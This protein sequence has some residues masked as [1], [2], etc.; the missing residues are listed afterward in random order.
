MLLRPCQ[1]GKG[2]HLAAGSRGW[3]LRNPSSPN[4]LPRN[5]LVLSQSP[6]P[7]QWVSWRLRS[8]Y[9]LPIPNPYPGRLRRL[10]TCPSRWILQYH[11][12][13]WG[14]RGSTRSHATC[15]RGQARA[16]ERTLGQ[17]QL[18]V[19]NSGSLGLKAHHPLTH[20]GLESGTGLEQGPATWPPQSC[21]HP[22]VLCTPAAGRP[23]P[24]AWTLRRIDRTPV[25]GAGPE[26]RQRW[27]GQTFTH[28]V[29]GGSNC[30]PE[31]FKYSLLIFNFYLKERRKKNLPP[32]GSLLPIAA[33]AR[34]EPI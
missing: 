32:A 10:G 17:A 1:A 2:E 22:K 18:S 34:A 12:C 9:M 31:V 5:V 28:E 11:M 27:L 14:C 3:G 7:A 4:P 8:S 6:G 25:L 33:T 15:N 29:D 16:R 23:L 20:T 19:P 21:P 30:T 24:R 13:G 26:L